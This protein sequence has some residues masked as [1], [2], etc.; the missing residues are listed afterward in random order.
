MLLNRIRYFNRGV[1]KNKIIKS[2]DKIKDKI[3][4]DKIIKSKDK[5]L[6]NKKDKK[7]IKHKMKQLLNEIALSGSGP[8]N[9]LSEKLTVNNGNFYVDQDTGNAY[10]FITNLGWVDLSS[11]Q[12][13][14][15]EGLPAEDNPPNPL[16]G[17]QYLD[18]LTGDFYIFVEGLGWI[19][20][21][22]IEGPQG[23]PGET[24][25][26]DIVTSMGATGPIISGPIKVTNGKTV[27]L[28][29]DNGYLQC[30]VI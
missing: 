4:K 27:Q 12:P 7:D 13:D 23:P 19:L 1:K 20:Q 30:D 17:D 18:M 26:F 25:S 16:S 15:G 9:E 3:I 21:S 22:G 10:L 5:I 2:K 8:P 11:W 24:F 28:W 14:I 6:R 29:M